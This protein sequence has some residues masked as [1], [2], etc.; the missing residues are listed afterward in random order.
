MLLGNAEIALIYNKSLLK[1]IAIKIDGL[2][3]Y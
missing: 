2:T 1:I 3:M